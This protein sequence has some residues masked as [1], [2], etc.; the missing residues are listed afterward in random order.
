MPGP[1]LGPVWGKV[2]ALVP[3][4]GPETEL[5]LVLAPELELAWAVG[6]AW[7]SALVRGPGL[8]PEMGQGLCL[9]RQLRSGRLSPLRH[10]PRHRTVT[11]LAAGLAQVGPVRFAAGSLAPF[12]PPDW[13]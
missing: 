8:G 3:G 7:V 9:R 5:A 11:G 2:R 10:R 6:Q 13:R 4:P 1:E 12:P